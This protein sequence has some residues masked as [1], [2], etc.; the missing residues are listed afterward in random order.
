[1]TR[2]KRDYLYQDYLGDLPQTVS[3]RALEYIA[4]EKRHAQKALND[5]LVTGSEEVPACDDSC[6]IW[7]QF[8]LP[9]RHTIHQRLKDK[10]ALTLQDLD[11]RWLLDARIDRQERYIRIRDPHPAER[12]RGRPRNEP[13]PVTREL[14]LPGQASPPPLG[15]QGPRSTPRG[16]QQSQR[17]SQQSQRGQRGSGRARNPKPPRG[18][19]SAGRLNPSVRRHLSQ[20]EMESEQPDEPE[21]GPGSDPEP[22]T[23]LGDYSGRERDPE[24]RP[25]PTPR[26]SK[27]AAS[28][29][30]VPNLSMGTTRSG[31]TVRPTARIRESQEQSSGPR[32]RPRTAH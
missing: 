8:R 25:R 10:E 7:L 3:L 6:T 19:A 27:P 5:A 13:I 20:W 31:R 16:S 28:Q 1:M 21:P 12:R 17:G 22:E 4:H 24:R 14:F 23:A 29:G 32:K 18:N 26:I 30:V 2:I 11:P 9:C 15:S